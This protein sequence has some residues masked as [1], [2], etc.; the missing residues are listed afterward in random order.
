MLALCRDLDFE[1][2]LDPDDISIRHIALSL[3]IKAST[4]S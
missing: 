4:G 3:E 2:T 1:I